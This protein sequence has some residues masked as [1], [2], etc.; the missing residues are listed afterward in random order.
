MS[1]QQAAVDPATH[2]QPPAS[3]RRLPAVLL[4]D[5]HPAIYL[6]TVGRGSRLAANCQVII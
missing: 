1:E 5:A 2:A 3:C 6:A 4:P